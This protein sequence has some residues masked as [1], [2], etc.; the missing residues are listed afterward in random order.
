MDRELRQAKDDAENAEY[1]AQQA[2]IE[3]SRAQRQIRE[4]K[5]NTRIEMGGLR[6]QYAA[7]EEDNRELYEALEELRKEL[8][9]L[10]AAK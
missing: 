2:G 10:K 5:E 6:E 7:L 9:A 4:M 8:A 1:L 3:A